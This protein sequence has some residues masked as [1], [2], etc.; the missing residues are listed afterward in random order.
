MSTRMKPKDEE[1]L[2]HL[3]QECPNTTVR[4]LL[5]TK[6]SS[7]TTTNTITA[8]ASSSSSSSGTASSLPFQDQPLP[9]AEH[10][11]QL[12]NVLPQ[13]SFQQ[14]RTALQEAQ[15][16]QERA[17]DILLRFHANKQSPVERLQRA[18]DELEKQKRRIEE[19]MKEKAE[20]EEMKERQSRG[21]QVTFNNRV[22]Q[23]RESIENSDVNNRIYLPGEFDA[24]SSG[25]FKIFSFYPERTFEMDATQIHFRMAESF[26]YRTAASACQLSRV[27][28]IVNPPLREQFVDYRRRAANQM[29]VSLEEVPAALML[30]DVP[31]HDVDAAV[32]QGLEVSPSEGTCFS[33]TGSQYPFRDRSRILLVH[34]LA[35]R[36]RHGASL[37]STSRPTNADSI[38]L[39]DFSEIKVFDKRAVLPM[40]ILY[41]KK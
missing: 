20:A 32:R 17:M 13:V 39:S 27:D 6:L 9:P 25:Q 3:I 40:Y 10:I 21:E 30:A 16:D 11:E 5:E 8:A 14:A 15:G 37:H 2:Q 34:V 24:L 35:S 7:N 36:P 23:T 29:R 41:I 26:L 4:Q 28:Y 38:A 31:D 12:Q 33:A 22:H 1:E 18:Q 19:L